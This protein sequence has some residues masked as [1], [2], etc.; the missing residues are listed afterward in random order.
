MGNTLKEEFIE[1]VRA[2]SDIVNVIN[3]YVTLK[4]KGKNYWGIC[5]FHGEKTPSF[6]VNPEKQLFYCFG[7]GAGGNIFTFISKKE[8]LSFVEAVKKLAQRANIPIPD[9]EKTPE[10]QQREQE[11]TE[12][13]A[14][15]KYT[16]ALFHSNL[17]KSAAADPARQYLKKRGILQQTIDKFQ[18]GYAPAE[19]DA[20][21][22]Q[23]Q[24]RGFS[25]QVIE[26]TGLCLPRGKG[27][28]YYDRFRSR[29]MFPIHNAQGAVVGFGGRVLDDT[30]P[31]Y[32]NSPETPLF[33]KRHQL[34][35]LHFA[36]PAIKNSGRVIVVEGYMDVITAQQ[37]GIGEVV[38]SL[39][40]A[41]T[42]EQAKLLLKHTYEV[43][44]AYDADA[45]GRSAALRGL[46]ILSGLGA[47][48]HVLSVPEGKDPDD[49]IRKRGQEAFLELLQNAKGLIPYYL[50]QAMAEEEITTPAGKGNVI[51][52]M[53]PLL[54]ALKNEIEID[55]YLRMIAGQ[56]KVDEAT[57]RRMWGKL[58]RKSGVAEDNKTAITGKNISDAGA[59]TE[60]VSATIMAEQDLIR[61][62]LE[63]TSL[64]PVAM[65]E[66]LLSMVNIEDHRQIMQRIFTVFQEQQ[67]VTVQAVGM[68]LDENACSVLS[69]ILATERGFDD[70]HKAMEGCIR[71]LRHN[72]R[73]QRIAGLER[74]IK[75]SEI[76]GETVAHDILTEYLQLVRDSKLFTEN[77]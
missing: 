56:L 44:I 77:A 41:L 53:F 49:F 11:R 9:G 18:L 31:K 16:A 5:P 68:K 1:H 30:Q 4:R 17:M 27:T 33:N 19:W 3:D 25:P 34:Y 47:N 20:L 37:Q 15:L 66:N 61:L 60:E 2:H 24:R 57:M 14:V 73:R 26:K 32:L 74:I 45:A 38:A 29:I 59:W 40:T 65:Q 62:M 46:G 70:I 42:P 10:E 28:G 12:L 48:V 6:S 58:A 55:E 67:N 63:E 23:L 22:K 72:Q 71:Y 64:I 21:F 7:C 13:L 75:E 35:G 76:K 39:G 69:K 43:Y 8:G 36:G 51:K 54:A 52:K 50:T